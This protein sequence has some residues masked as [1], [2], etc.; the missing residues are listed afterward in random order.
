[1]IENKFKWVLPFKTEDQVGDNRTSA[2]G[3]VLHNSTHDNIRQEM[4]A[5]MVKSGY[6]LINSTIENRNST[7]P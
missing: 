1:M 5:E 6:R 2:E 7:E 3:Q 4:M